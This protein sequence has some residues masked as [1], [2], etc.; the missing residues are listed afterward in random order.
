[1]EDSRVGA[2]SGAFQN[3]SLQCGDLLWMTGQVIIWSYLVSELRSLHR[4]QAQALTQK[5]VIWE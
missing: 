1:M 3:E 4:I 5:P 2:C